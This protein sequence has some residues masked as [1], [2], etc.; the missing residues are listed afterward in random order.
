MHAQRVTRDTPFYIVLNTR[1]GT[2]KAGA[3]QAEMREVL[4]G[5]RQAHEFI[6][7]EEPS[8]TPHVAERVARI[9]AQNDGAIIVGGGD[10]TINSVAHASLATHRPFGV[11]PQGTFNYLSRAYGIPSDPI[12]ATRALLDARLR[13]IQVGALNDRIFLVNASLGLHP[14]LLEERESYTHQYGRKRVVALW[15]GLSTLMRGYRQLT[16]EIEHDAD[17]EVVRTPTLF[18]GNNPLQLERVGLPEAEV[19]QQD[20][21]A[22]VIVRPVG[23]AALLWLALR[24]ALGQLGED[25]NVRNFS[26]RRLS[27]QHI[28]G[29]PGRR[30]KVSTDGEI[31]WMEPPLQFSVAPQRLMLMVPAPISNSGGE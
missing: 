19:V 2:G 10:G 8:D 12:E 27:V 14:H 13:P 30:I 9:A 23:V 26:F 4:Q 31:L 20:R 21:L 25:H 16:I 11:I 28:R 17:R 15:A 1:S 29:Q 7:I 5:A 22:A 24:G 6:L 3:I 18:V